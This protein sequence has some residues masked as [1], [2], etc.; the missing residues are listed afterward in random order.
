M[1]QDLKDLLGDV[2]KTQDPSSRYVFLTAYLYMYLGVWLATL[3][4]LW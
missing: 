3:L 4:L 2:Q 1:F